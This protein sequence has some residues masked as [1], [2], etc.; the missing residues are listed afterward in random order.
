[1]A[2]LTV[3]I[4]LTCEEVEV[5]FDSLA[6]DNSKVLQFDD[7]QL[8]TANIFADLN[9]M[10]DTV[11]YTPTVAPLTGTMTNYSTAGNWYR[12]GEYM[13]IEAR[14]VFSG[15]SGTWANPTISIP[16]GYLV[17]SSK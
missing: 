14:V 15:A 11:S 8:S 17:D 13:H 12:V 2:S 7:I 3:T 5:A 4:P 10:T 16:S 1:T 6:T 9:N